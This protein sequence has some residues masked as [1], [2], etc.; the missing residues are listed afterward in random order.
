MH[1]GKWQSHGN[2]TRLGARSGL[3]L[4]Y[5]VPD[6]EQKPLHL[7]DLWCPWSDFLKVLWS[8]NYLF[9]LNFP[10]LVLFKNWLLVAKKIFSFK[11]QSHQ[12]LE[13][14]GIRV[15]IWGKEDL[16]IYIMHLYKKGNTLHI[17]SSKS[18]AQD[19]LV[20]GSKL[21]MSVVFQTVVALFPYDTKWAPGSC[22]SYSTMT[23]LGA[24]FMWPQFFPQT[25]L[26][27]TGFLQLSSLPTERLSEADT[28]CQEMWAKSAVS[29]APSSASLACLTN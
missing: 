6:K 12:F 17:S 16:C 1:K 11:T 26:L 27:W 23:D 5:W 7:N 25:G 10:A 18:H 8:L 29:R 22:P 2:R 3:E 24:L 13:N 14:S 9:L 15:G 4:L 19:F 20:V 21:W 28:K